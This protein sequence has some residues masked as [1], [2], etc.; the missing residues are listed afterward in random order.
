MENKENKESK[1]E[2]PVN[3]DTMADFFRLLDRQPEEKLP[4]NT[5]LALLA[6]YD[7]SQIISHVAGGAQSDR[8]SQAQPLRD[9]LM[10]MLA[11]QG[12]P[13]MGLNDMA[14]MLDTNPMAA[15]AEMA[16]SL[17]R[18]PAA[19]MSLLSML[20]GP[21]P[22]GARPPMPPTTPASPQDPTRRPD[23]GKRQ[24]GGSK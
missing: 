4:A 22:G 21:G 7:L 12:N 5:L 11:G 24:F 10:S 14:R 2:P 1:I 16:R 18:N 13:N 19:L 9:A 15:M 3:R 6:L 8:K 20:A 23:E 17:D